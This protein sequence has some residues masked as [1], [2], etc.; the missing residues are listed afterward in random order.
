MKNLII[1][2]ATILLA[3]TATFASVTPETIIAEK[4]VEVML[5][6]DMNIFTTAAYDQTSENLEFTTQSD[7]EFIQI[8]DGQGNVA[9]QLPVQSNIVKINK[10]LFDKGVS[11]LGFK[12]NE[13]T[14]TYYTSVKV[15]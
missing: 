1:T 7:I 11:R 2:F 4:E 12:M 14:E 13:T 3:A 8:Y 6:A 9:F 5:V 15:N 10:N